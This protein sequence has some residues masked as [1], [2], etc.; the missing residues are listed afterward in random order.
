MVWLGHGLFCY[1]LVGSHPISV[2]HTA[3]VFVHSLCKRASYVLNEPMEIIH[4][5]HFFG[6]MLTSFAHFNNWRF[7]SC[8]CVP[9]IHGGGV[10]LLK[11]VLPFSPWWGRFCFDSS[12]G[13]VGWGQVD[14]WGSGVLGSFLSLPPPTSCCGM[15]GILGA[16]HCI[17]Y[18]PPDP[19]VRVCM[20]VCP[21]PHWLNSFWQAYTFIH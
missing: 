19:C 8:M 18:A 16:C 2:N 15:T 10:P 3:A 12:D 5:V 7:I 14:F 11:M 6:E 21:C 13:H 17:S 9:C 20:C 4:T 1:L